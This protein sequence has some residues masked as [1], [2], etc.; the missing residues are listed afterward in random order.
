MRTL[1]TN[2]DPKVHTVIDAYPEL[3]QEK[4][5]NL[6]DLVLETAHE[7]PEVTTLEITLKWGEPSFVTNVGSTLRM[8]WKEKTPDQYALYFQ[9]TSRLVDT[10][11]LVFDEKFKFEGS[12]AMIFHLDQKIPETALKECIK[13]CLRYHK[14]KHLETLG[15]L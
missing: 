11:R 12:R 5:K 15:I 3:V 4:L 9:C 2:V 14:V 10:F 1:L 6:Q 8:D 7:T 13:A